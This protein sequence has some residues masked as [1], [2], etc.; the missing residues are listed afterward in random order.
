MEFIKTYKKEIIFFSIFFLIILAIAGWFYF[1]IY[2]GDKEVEEKT[3]QGFDLSDVNNV[4]AT[5]LISTEPLITLIKALNPVDKDI[6]A[7]VIIVEIESAIFFLFALR[8]EKKPLMGLVCFA[9]SFTAS[10][11][12]FSITEKPP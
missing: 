2:L 9:V 10:V 8:A 5:S 11:V 3:N 12:L 7:I 6:I 4:D 1:V